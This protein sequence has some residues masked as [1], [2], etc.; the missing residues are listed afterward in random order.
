MIKVSFPI[1]GNYSVPAAYFLKKVLN[2]EIILPNNITDKTIESGNYHSPE[3]VCTPFKYTLG[4]YIEA[5]D[6]GANV[7]FQAGGGCRYGYYFELQEKILKDLG[8]NFKYVNLISKGVTDYKKIYKQLK[9]INEDI[10]IDKILYYLFIT[11]K[12]LKYMDK[13]DD[14]IRQNIGFELNK[15]EFE[16]TNNEMLEKFSKI[17]NYFQLKKIYIKYIKKLKK[18]K[19]NKPKNTLKIGIIGELYTV[20]EPYA[21][22]YLEKELASYNIEIKRYT[23]AHY[24][25]FEKGK[26]VKKYLKYAKEYIKYRMGA[27]AA[28]NIGRAKYLCENKYD[29]IIHIKSSFC[30]PEIGAMAI[31]NKICKNY[32]VPVIFFSFDANTSEVGIKT[33]IEAF[34]DMIE[35]R[36]KN[37]ELLSRN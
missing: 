37:E 29:G 18:I 6:K 11:S 27:D 21:N 12:M 28:D 10:K 20:M 19:T 17:K 2:C 25:I 32:N 33:R 8:Y 13:C 24:L 5:L 36:K 15:G 4:C 1:M 16:K 34:Y 7:L 26:K 3:F 23:N 35:M 22:Y 9:E 31:I 14:Y 30:T